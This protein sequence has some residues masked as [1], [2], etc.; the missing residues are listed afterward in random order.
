[1]ADIDR[2]TRYQLL[3]NASLTAL[4]ASATSIYTG[5]AE[6]NSSF[7]Y[8]VI[9]NIDRNDIRHTG[10]STNVRNA[11]LKFECVARE[12]DDSRAIGELVDAEF[13]DDVNTT[14]GDGGT[15]TILAAFRQGDGDDVIPP[16][17]GSPNPIFVRSISY[18]FWYRV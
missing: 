1:M 5:V 16:E 11:L 7:P 14:Y 18:L 15:T 2:D 13:R 3:Q 4:L 9:S 8:I 12:Y 17:D 6:Q 10:G